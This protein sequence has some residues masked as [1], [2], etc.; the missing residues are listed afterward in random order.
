M[1]VE[2]DS[3]IDG[4]AVGA[5]RPGLEVELRPRSVTIRLL[6]DVTVIIRMSFAKLGALFQRATKAN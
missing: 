6:H 4:S 5:A 2:P 3:S 1:L